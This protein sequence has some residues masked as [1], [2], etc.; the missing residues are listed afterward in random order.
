VQ[1]LMI[2]GGALQGWLDVCEG[3][4][5]GIERIVQSVARSRSDGQSIHLTYALLLLDRA[6]GMAGELQEG[7]AATREGLS[8]T[9][10]RNQRYLAT[11]LWRVD[12]E[13]THRSGEAEAAVASLRNAVEIAS[14]QGAVWSFGRCTRSP[15]DFPVKHCASNTPRHDMLAIQHFR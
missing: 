8:L 5:R 3:P 6:R 9:H 12:G 10:R 13:L 7:R 4:P 1:Y 14:K 2:V 11:E 15:V